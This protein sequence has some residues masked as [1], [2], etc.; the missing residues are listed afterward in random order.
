MLENLTDYIYI[1]VAALFAI[2]LHEIAHGLVSTWLGDP[3]PKRQGR[4]SLN[5]L[6]HLDPI[7]TLCLIFFHVGW[8]KPVVVN[9]DYYKNKKRG[10]ALVALAGPLMNFLLAIFSIIIMAIFVKVNAYSNV[11]I[12]IYN[13]LLYFSVINLG[14]GLFNLIPIPPLD[15]S[16]ILGAFLKDDTY[17][18]YMKYERYGFIIIAIL[19][20]LSSLRGNGTSF[21]SELVDIIFNFIFRLVLKIFGVL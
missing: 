12:I 20:A 7:G 19:L 14:L 4:L 3:T 10:M 6:K 9:P 8:A 5:P 17:E 16:R 21:I 1:V 13:F 2:I 11:L 18:Q 15:G